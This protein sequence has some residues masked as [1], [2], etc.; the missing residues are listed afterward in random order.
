MHVLLLVGLYFDFMGTAA[1]HTTVEINLG[2]ITQTHQLMAPREVYAT[3]LH[4][5]DFYLSL[6][7]KSKSVIDT[8][9][10]ST[11]VFRWLSSLSEQ[12]LLPGA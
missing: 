12:N 8:R 5:F 2:M 3:T 11:A 1:A 6:C 9:F 4:Y 7:P 10:R